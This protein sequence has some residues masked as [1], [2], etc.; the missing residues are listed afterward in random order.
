MP[1]SSSVCPTAVTEGEHPPPTVCTRSAERISAG[2]I[3]SSGRLDAHLHIRLWSD[4]ALDLWGLR[5]DEVRGQSF[6][7]LDIGLEVVA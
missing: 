5:V 4:E 6:M 2:E 7:S 3:S 1:A